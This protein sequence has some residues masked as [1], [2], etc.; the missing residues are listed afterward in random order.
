MDRFLGELT[1]RE[2]GNVW[3]HKPTFKDLRS[4]TGLSIASP[5]HMGNQPKNDHMTT[6]Y[7][8]VLFNILT[9]YTVP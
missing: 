7:I 6:C 5:D 4:I 8:C 2:I 9:S 1:K 3:Q